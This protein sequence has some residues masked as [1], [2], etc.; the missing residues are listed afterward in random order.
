VI[1][2]AGA[3][4]Q[5]HTRTYRSL[6]AARLLGVCDVDAATL[7][8]AAGDAPVGRRYQDYEALLA[9]PEVEAVS[10]CTPDG[11]HVGPAVAAAQAGKHVLLEKPIATTLEDARTIVR[12]CSAAG[13]VLL[14]GHVL[15]FDP[16]FVAAREAL[17]AGELGDL[18]TVFARRAN[19]VGAQD[20]LRG[21]VR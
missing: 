12:A 5:V 14:V 10:V 13:V 3:M 2:A 6:P 19:G 18:L 17:S 8:A 21:R 11:Q 20:R 9:D 16:R 1:G 15:R 4:G 7:A